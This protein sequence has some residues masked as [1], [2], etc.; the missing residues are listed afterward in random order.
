MICQWYCKSNFP[1]RL[2]GYLKLASEP[3]DPCPVS[4]RPPRLGVKCTRRPDATE[5]VPILST[6]ATEDVTRFCSDLGASVPRRS[7]SS[8]RAGSGPISESLISV[9]SSGG[10]VFRTS[11]IAGGIRAVL[12]SAIW[13]VEDVVHPSRYYLVQD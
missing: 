6:I 1:C 8:L 4:R 9:A 10:S 2:V 3:T 13:R 5:L 11:Q 7:P 12:D